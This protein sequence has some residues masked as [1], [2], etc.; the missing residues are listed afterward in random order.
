MKVM[1][2]RNENDV[3][4]RAGTKISSLGSFSTWKFLNQTCF[5][6]SIIVEYCGWIFTF[7]V[8]HSTCPDLLHGYTESYQGNAQQNCLRNMHCGLRN[9]H[10]GLSWQEIQL[11]VNR[12]NAFSIL[13][14]CF[15]HKFLQCCLHPSQF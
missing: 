10:C 6:Y 7:Y 15:L 12:S 9:M 5:D 11:D 4:E 8:S 13:E 2:D 1:C 3:V 14:C